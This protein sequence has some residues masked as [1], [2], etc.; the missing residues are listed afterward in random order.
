MHNTKNKIATRQQMINGEFPSECEYCWKVERSEDYSDRIFKSASDW[1]KINITDLTKP[2]VIKNVNP[3]YLEVSFSSDCNLKCAYCDP[4]VSSAIRNEIIKYGHYPTSDRFGNLDEY[5]PGPINLSQ[6]FWQWWDGSLKDDLLVLR[7]TGGEPL[8]SPDLFKLV[9]KI[10]SGNQHFQFDFAVNSNLM[11]G[12]EL[13]KKF[14]SH[15]LEIVKTKKVKSFTLYTSIDTWGEHAEFLRFGLK[16]NLFVTN[17]ESCLNIM[18]NLEL[19]FMVTYQA[20][21][22]FN[23]NQLLEFIL[24]LRKRYPKSKIKIGI[25][26]L[27]NP[28]FLSIHLFDKS[29]GTYIESNLKFMRSHQLSKNYPQGFSNFEIQHLERIFNAFN[30]YPQHS[31]IEMTNFKNFISE[32]EIR[33]KISSEKAFSHSEVFGLIH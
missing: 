9:D 27:L 21:S 29:F 19:T 15:M 4:T 7:V 28:R 5:Q 2:E 8:L 17:I 25:S 32:Y 14:I 26:S 12:P 11:V 24:D 1:A 20:L 18:P 31:E 10:N 22:P 33:K 30:N 6:S 13:L 16:T 3:S 23:F